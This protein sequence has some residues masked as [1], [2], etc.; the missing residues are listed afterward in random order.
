MS[1]CKRTGSMQMTK[2]HF[3]NPTI[4]VGL[5]PNLEKSP[6]L[7]QIHIFYH[8]APYFQIWLDFENFTLVICM[9]SIRFQ[10]RI[11]RYYISFIS[12][13]ISNNAFLAQI[14]QIRKFGLI[15]LKILV[16]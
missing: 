6:I 1:R 13:V 12:Q 8:W 2:E 11:N 5:G 16:C 4:F 10:R 7:V 15:P 9:L 14:A 3:Q